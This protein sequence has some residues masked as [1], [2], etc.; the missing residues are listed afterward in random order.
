MLRPHISPAHAGKIG[1]IAGVAIARAILEFTGADA[2]LKWPNDVLIGRRKVCGILT[3]MSAECD[4]VNFVVCGMGLNVNETEFSP[5][6]RQIAT[7]LRLETGQEWIRGQILLTILTQFFERYDAW[8]D[9]GDYTPIV[10]EYTR[11]SML[12]GKMVTVLSQRSKLTG[13]CVGFDKDGYL[14]IARMA[15]ACGSFPAMSA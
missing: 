12:V 2:K 5:E 6:L 8:V 13:Q 10:E 14:V 7:S 9:T 3:E 4:A 1:Q 15:N 11:M